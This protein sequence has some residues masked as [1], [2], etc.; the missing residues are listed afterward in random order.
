[1]EV[2]YKFTSQ[3]PIYITFSQ[4]CKAYNSI[5]N[6]HPNVILAEKLDMLVNLITTLLAVIIAV[7]ATRNEVDLVSENLHDQLA[8]AQIRYQGKSYQ[9]NFDRPLH[10]EC[11]AK[12]GEAL[13]Q[14]R[15]VY[16]NRYRDR[17]WN[18]GCAKVVSIPL[19]DCSWPV[20]INHWQAPI[21]FMCPKGKVMAGVDSK[22]WDN[23]EDRRW[24]I[25][26]CSAKG[27][28]T[29]ECELTKQLNNDKAYFE[30]KASSNT[31]KRKCSKNRHKGDTQRAFVGIVSNW[32]ANDRRWQMLECDVGK[33]TGHHDQDK[34]SRHGHR[35]SSCDSEDD[36]RHHKSRNRGCSK[37]MCR[38][39]SEE[40]SRDHTEG[41]SHDKSHDKSR[42]K[43]RSK[44]HDKSHDK[45][46]SKPRSKSHDK[47]RSRSHNSRDKT[48]RHQVSAGHRGCSSCSNHY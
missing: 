43:S 4:T 47:S 15:S 13:N 39:K 41:K 14:V 22:H 42:S 29:E 34:N 8:E 26:C 40:N 10:F 38:K 16:H 12:N 46:H 7:E 9:N 48:H 3:R 35:K 19:S 27:Y 32:R 37:G 36:T 21:R 17:L 20:Y 25:K 30:H 2:E 11:N 6:N 23:K 33:D 28:H 31:N 5:Y 24:K 18:W 44:S 45:S 1:M